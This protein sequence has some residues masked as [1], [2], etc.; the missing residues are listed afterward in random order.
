MS[1]RYKSPP[2]GVLMLF[3]SMTES[4]SF[5]FVNYKLLR[6]LFLGG[7][8]SN[9]ALKLVGTFFA[10][11]GIFE[12]VSGIISGELSKKQAFLIASSLLVCG[13]LGLTVSHLLSIANI[14]QIF[15]CIIWVAN[16]S[17]IIDSNMSDIYRHCESEKLFGQVDVWIIRRALISICSITAA[18]ISEI[19]NSYYIFLILSILNVLSFIIYYLYIKDLWP[20]KEL[21]VQ[22]TKREM[23]LIIFNASLMPFFYLLAGQQY[24]ISLGLALLVGFICQLLSTKREKFHFYMFLALSQYVA[25]LSFLHAK[26]SLYMMIASLII[27][28]VMIARDINNRSINTEL[29]REGLI[30]LI[31]E[32]FLIYL[33][34]QC[35]TVVVWFIKNQ[36]SGNILN[37]SISPVSMV[38]FERLTTL[39]FCIFAIYFD[40]DKFQNN[41]KEEERLNDPIQI[42]AYGSI[43]IGM[44]FLYLF[45]I[46][47]LISPPISNIFLVPYYVLN[48]FIYTK[49]LNI[50]YRAAYNYFD[51]K[52]TKM[53]IGLLSILA[54]V[55]TAAAAKFYEHLVDKSTTI[56]DYGLHFASTATFGIAFGVLCLLPQ[57][58]KIIL[59]LKKG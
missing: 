40:K 50:S 4:L 44:N 45:L 11:S 19:L 46:S 2:T 36:C 49:I 6:L 54:A 7:L 13:T 20:K 8:E 10:I 31:Q 34:S 12:F 47:L 25:V 3:L 24:G 41:V 33:Y 26:V 5:N 38:S 27:G 17:A 53:V 1:K 56:N 55:G 14:N 22:E 15:L 59:K 51:K 28:I 58:K 43:I 21:I 42:G 16:G 48:A 32:S 9:S 39:A 57:T 52:W 23:G 29:H 37:W 18:F 35:K 30:W